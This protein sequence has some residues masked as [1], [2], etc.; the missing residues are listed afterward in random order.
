MI[1]TAIKKFVDRIKSEVFGEMAK[2]EKITIPDLK[3]LHKKLDKR[4]SNTKVNHEYNNWCSSL[5]V[6]GMYTKHY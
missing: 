1:K 5:N 3:K 6:G 2:G 4:M